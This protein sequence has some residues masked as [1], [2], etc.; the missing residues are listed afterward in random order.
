[1]NLGHVIS[2]PISYRGLNTACGRNTVEY[3]S[4][5]RTRRSPASRLE[6]IRK[7]YPVGD[8]KLCST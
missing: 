1:M 5:S 8:S 3:R 7:R 2:V 4:A 6:V